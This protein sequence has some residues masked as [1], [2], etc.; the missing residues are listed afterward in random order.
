MQNKESGQKTKIQ[1]EEGQYVIYLWLLTRGEEAWEE[2]EKVLKGSRFAILA[3][4][5]EQVSAGGCE[6]CKSA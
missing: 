6:C 4:E 5:S 1:Y 3:T 2:T